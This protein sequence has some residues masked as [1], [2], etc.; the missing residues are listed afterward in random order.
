MQAGRHTLTSIMNTRISLVSSFF[1]AAGVETCFPAT[2]SFHCRLDNQ[3]KIT[4]NVS[5]NQVEY[6]SN[7]ME[8]CKLKC[9]SCFRSR[10]NLA[11]FNL[12]NMSAWLTTFHRME[13]CEIPASTSKNGSTKFTEHEFDFIE[14]TSECFKAIVSRVSQTLKWLN[15]SSPHAPQFQL[16]REHKM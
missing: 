2:L 15:F 8:F 9:Q 16:K 10:E 3:L 6:S 1:A 12:P 4:L 14:I 5:G 7:Q 11:H 13:N